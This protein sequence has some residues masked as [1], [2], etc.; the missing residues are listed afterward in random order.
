MMRK[1]INIQNSRRLAIF[2]TA[3]IPVAVLSYHEKLSIGDISSLPLFLILVLMLI[4]SN[5]EIPVYRMRTKKPVHLSRDALALEHI[6]A[7]PVLE[8]LSTG[9]QRTFDTAVT[10]NAGGFIV[11][12]IALLYLLS[13]HLTTVAL[14]LTLI[15][16]IAVV[17]IS[18][19][20]SGVGVVIPDHTPLIAIP[21]ALMVD[22]S[23]VAEIT[24][25]SAIAGIFIGTLVSILTFN[26]EKK[27]SAYISLG[28]AGNF[29][30][31]YFT[32]LI[33]GLLSYFI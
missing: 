29:P 11:P 7:V 3:L 32:V 33:A 2:C 30:A 5:L 18:E 20:I 13:T 28:G 9:S 14:L 16:I 4:F 25:I 27:G 22:P 17:L 26:R 31:I 23:H 19:M 8:E 24:Y 1:Y 10:V 6:Y 21:F 12:L 15:M